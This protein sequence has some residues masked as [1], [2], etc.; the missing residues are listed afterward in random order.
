M[1]VNGTIL[2]R[3][4]ATAVA[5][6]AMVAA[7]GACSAGGP[8]SAS[9]AGGVGVAPAAAQSAQDGAQ[10]AMGMADDVDHPGVAHAGNKIPCT[11]LAVSTADPEPVGDGS[12]QWRLPIEFTN[13]TDATCSVRGFPG[14][15]L[16]GGDGETWDLTR[17][18]AKISPVVLQPGQHTEASLTFLP[19][20][21]ADGWK[22]LTMAVT[23]PN[24]TDTQMV[25][26]PL[27]KIVRQDG[28][29][30]PGTYIDPVH[31]AG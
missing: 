24:T 22:V 25:N 31:V 15:R 12:A 7:L 16:Q 20:Q 27:G 11:T 28:A 10:N 17:T 23:P 19:D 6:G 1:N 30:H 18:D 8:Q 4:A 5:V 26:W 14:V 21:S 3:G 2:R 29:T 13:Q 9:A